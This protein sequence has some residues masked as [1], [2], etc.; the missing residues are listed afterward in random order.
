LSSKIIVV[1]VAAA[2]AD[3]VCSPLCEATCHHYAEEENLK[4]KRSVAVLKVTNAFT[5]VVYRSGLQL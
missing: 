4:L 2:V 1:V 5:A 3:N